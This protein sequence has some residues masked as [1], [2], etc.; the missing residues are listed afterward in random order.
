MAPKVSSRMLV[1]KQE[2]EID[3]A[4]IKRLEDLAENIIEEEE[5][6]I[7]LADEI[8]EIMEYVAESLKEAMEAETGAEVE[9]YGIEDYHLTGDNLFRAVIAYRVAGTPVK[10]DITLELELEV[11]D[12]LD[13]VVRLTSRRVSIE[14]G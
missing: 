12:E 3:W 11:T 14:V 9:L 6:T 2:D 7:P 1:R 10:A 5:Y 4:K 13:L 8:M